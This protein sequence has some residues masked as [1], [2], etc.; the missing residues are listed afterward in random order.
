V[1]LSPY[2]KKKGCAAK[3]LK[4]E[5]RLAAQERAELQHTWRRWTKAEIARIYTAAHV[6]ALL[7]EARQAEAARRGDILTRYPD[8]DLQS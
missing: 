7:A 4:T 5:Q 8:G 2:P 1:N 3:R 6:D